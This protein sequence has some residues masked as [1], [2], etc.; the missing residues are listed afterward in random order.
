MVPPFLSAI[1]RSVTEHESQKHEWFP[2]A[3]EHQ[4]WLQNK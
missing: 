4:G 2:A 1:P 3:K